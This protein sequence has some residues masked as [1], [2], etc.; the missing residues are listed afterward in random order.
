MLKCE[1]A[2]L[3]SQNMDPY[4]AFTMSR[5]KA[6][7]LKEIKEHIKEINNIQSTK[8]ISKI[9]LNYMYNY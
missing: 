9:L 5:S 3:T 8:K 7:I 4:S 6:Q 2:V 1:L